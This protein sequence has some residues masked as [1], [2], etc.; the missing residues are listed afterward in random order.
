M[1][2]AL[3]SCQRPRISSYIIYEEHDNGNVDT[4]IVEVTKLT[5]TKM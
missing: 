4:K 1:K 5:K 2:L 3:F